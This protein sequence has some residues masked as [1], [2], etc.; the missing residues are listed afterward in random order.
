MS[1]FCLLWIPLFYLFRRSISGGEAGSGGVWALLLGSLTAITRFFIGT[2]VNA[3]GFGLSRWIGGFVDIVGLPVLLPLIVY[4]LLVL[5]RILSGAVD[6]AN[7]ALLWLIPVGALRAV[8]WSAGNDP[9]LLVLVP[10]LWTAAAVGIPFFIKLIL[11]MMRWWVIVPCTLGI[12]ALP[13]TIST[14]YWAFYSQETSLA[15]L[16]FFISIIPLT[17]S[18]IFSFVRAG[19]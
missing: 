17:I 15:L 8:S 19:R 2:F 11:N 12:L 18:T 6:F 4:T 7:F 16:F 10:L 14:A 3:G 5:F 9:I 13:L 1:F